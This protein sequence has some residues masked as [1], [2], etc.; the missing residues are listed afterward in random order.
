VG[1]ADLGVDSQKMIKVKAYFLEY[2]ERLSL[3]AVNLT[4]DIIVHGKVA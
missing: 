1:S 4:S 2:D 3:L